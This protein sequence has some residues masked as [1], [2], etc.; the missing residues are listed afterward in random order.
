VSQLN[1]YGLALSAAYEIFMDLAIA[2]DLPELKEKGYVVKEVALNENPLAVD[3]L[4]ILT[5][6]NTI[7]ISVSIQTD[8]N[9]FDVRVHTGRETKEILRRLA[10]GGSPAASKK[11][12]N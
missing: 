7:I 4:L 8:E 6:D 1:D 10:S 12:L 9:D 11:Y 3:K 2:H 5:K